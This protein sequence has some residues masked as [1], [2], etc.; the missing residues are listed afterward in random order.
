MSE[1]RIEALGE[2]RFKVAGPLS[3]ET[4]KPLLIRSTAEFGALPRVEI[5]LSG[6]TQ[7]DSA[8]LALL[9]QWMRQARAQQQQIRFKNI[10]SQL[11]ALA[12][13]SDLDELLLANGE[14]H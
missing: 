9:V 6:V 14:V 7:S 3:F 5:D 1:T 8:G 11:L 13:I 4:V 10:P 2:G 12:Q